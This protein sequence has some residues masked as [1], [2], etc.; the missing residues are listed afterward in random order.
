MTFSHPLFHRFCL[1]LVGW[2]SLGWFLLPSASCADV[3]WRAG[4]ARARITPTEPIVLGGYAN[5][6]E[7]YRRVIQDLHVKALALEDGRGFRVVLLTCDV[8]GFRAPAATAILDRIC[9]QS[10]LERSQILLNSSHTHTAPAPSLPLGTIVNATGTTSWERYHQRLLDSVVETALSALA[11]LRPAKLS[12]GSGIAT[13][14]MNRR[15]PTPQGIKLGFNPRG[16][17][18]RSVPVLRVAD[19]NGTLRGIV[20][21]AACHATTIPPRD[22]EVTGDYPGFAQDYLENQFPGVQAMFMQGFGGDAG[23]YPSG[24]LDY[25]RQHG[26]TLGA[27]VKQVLEG[28]SLVEVHGPLKTAQVFADLPLA[29]P[30]SRREI[31]ALTASPQLWQKAAA[32]HMLMQL[33]KGVVPLTTYRAPFTL[34]QFGQDLT[35]VALP[36]EVVGDYVAGIERVLGPLR[37]WLSGYNNDVF[38]YLPSARVLRE[39]GYETRGLYSGERFDPAV[40]EHAIG[41]V[42]ELARSVGRSLP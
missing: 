28:T 29:A 35:L 11:D 18:D 19:V 38:G 27:E 36:G 13:F 31:E 24:R 17:A 1:A 3:E 16:P 42:R 40:E 34:W 15:E 2:V 23:P 12:H 32:S 21:G 26:A 22:N 25:A 8:L 7:P 5:R 39:G 14:V 37:L 9:A 4:F 33:E 30:L 10:G 41:V 20:F 6:Q